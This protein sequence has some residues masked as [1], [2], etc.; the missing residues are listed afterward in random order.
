MFRDWFDR[1]PPRQSEDGVRVR[2]NCEQMEDRC[3]PADITSPNM[4]VTTPQDVSNPADGLVSLREA[5]DWSNTHAPGAGNRN[6]IE[7]A[8][9]LKNNPITLKGTEGGR[10]VLSQDTYVKADNRAWYTV[11]RDAAT[12]T[13]GLF[14]VSSG[15]A[16]TFE[17]LTLKGGLAPNGEGGG[18]IL[19]S[20]NLSVFACDVRGNAAP[21]DAGGLGGFGGGIKGLAESI[22]LNGTT[23]AD[24]TAAYGGGVAASLATTLSVTNSAVSINTATKY[25]GGVYAGTGKVT[26][27]NTQIA[28]NTADL[29]GGGIR[30]DGGELTLKGGSQLFDNTTNGY[31]GGVYI[32]GGKIVYVQVTIGDNKA[33]AGKGDGVYRAGT[34][35]EGFDFINVQWKNDVEVSV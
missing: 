13:F 17:G 29:G 16:A 25:G 2:L 30:V 23:V 7:F 15:V 24:N 9:F 1:L 28:A 31:G 19:S 5:V 18:A 33:P 12:G 27:D 8:P 34:V 4:F 22:T 3:N 20:G 14:Q 32:T 10:L 26:I 35:R 11:T 6:K 21:L